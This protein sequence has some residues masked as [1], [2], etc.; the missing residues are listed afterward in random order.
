MAPCVDT[1]AHM[2]LRVL[3]HEQTPPEKVRAVRTAALDFDSEADVSASYGTKA[4]DPVSVL[5][6][7]LVAPF[8]AGFAGKAG[9]DAW[10]ELRNL[11]SRLREA[12]GGD[13]QVVIEDSEGV[14][15]I[16]SESDSEELL[17][18]LPDDVADAAGEY[19]ELYYDAGDG[20]WKSQED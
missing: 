9:S 10:D 18:E 6:L 5:L 15:V 2:S 11:V 3:M 17:L 12:H 20:V 8:V 14:Q 1:V 16:L 4:V 7:F 19:R 13:T